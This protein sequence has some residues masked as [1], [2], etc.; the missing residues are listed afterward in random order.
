[1]LL[2]FDQKKSLIAGCLGGFAH[3]TFYF[4]IENNKLFLK[5]PTQVKCSALVHF[6]KNSAAGETL[7]AFIV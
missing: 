4:L 2:S 5:V 1:M 6:S 3:S 7:G